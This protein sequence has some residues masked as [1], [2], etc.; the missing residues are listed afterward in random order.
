MEE[1][2]EEKKII[3]TRRSHSDKPEGSSGLE[4]VVL[5]EGRV[6]GSV[7]GVK[8]VGREGGSRGRSG[9]VKVVLGAVGVEAPRQA[10]LPRRPSAGL[11]QAPGKRTP[12]CVVDLVRLCVLYAWVPVTKNN[13]PRKV[14]GSGGMPPRKCFKTYN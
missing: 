1:C 3:I 14:G 7:G 11:R 6:V 2:R 13:N 4:G 8:G 12:R 5:Q 9:P 10:L